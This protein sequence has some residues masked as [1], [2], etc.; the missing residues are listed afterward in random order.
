MLLCHQQKTA[1]SRD[2]IEAVLRGGAVG[3]NSEQLAEMLDRV[4]QQLH[5][6]DYE[7]LLF[8]L[9]LLCVARGGTCASAKVAERDRITRHIQVLKILLSSIREVKS[10]TLTFISSSK[11]HGRL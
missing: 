2:R 6:T 1:R 7:K 8:T 10:G 9:E 5:A 11:I 4:I 3:R